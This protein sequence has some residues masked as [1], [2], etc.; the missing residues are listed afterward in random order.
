MR[1]IQSYVHRAQVGVLLEL[2]TNDESTTRKDEFGELARDL[3][4]QVAGAKAKT[5]DELLG[6]QFIKDPQQLVSHRIYVVSTVLSAPIRVT[7]F[8]RY[9]ANAA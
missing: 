4:L 1:Y 5:I 3:A 6:Q 7:R 9:D 8:V 2:E